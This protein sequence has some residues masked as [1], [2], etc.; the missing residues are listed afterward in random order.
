MLIQRVYRRQEP[1]HAGRTRPRVAQAGARAEAGPKVRAALDFRGKSY[2]AG[3]KLINDF[4]AGLRGPRRSLAGRENP[5][6][7]GISTGAGLH[8][9]GGRRPRRRDR[10]SPSWQAKTCGRGA[11]TEA[12]VIQRGES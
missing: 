12:K 10:P 4:V 8:A 7:E 5:Y 1:A 3:G 9:R 6:P 2:P 11:Q